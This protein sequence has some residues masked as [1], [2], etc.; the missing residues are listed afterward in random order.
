[1]AGSRRLW[2]VWMRQAMERATATD[3]GKE[4]LLA[5]YSDP[6]NTEWLESVLRELYRARNQR[7]EAFGLEKDDD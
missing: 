2:K 5:Y 4:A 1:M 3:S 6:K 7:R